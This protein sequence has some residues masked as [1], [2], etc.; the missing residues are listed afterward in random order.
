M[1]AST[2]L[3]TLSSLALLA[4]CGGTPSSSGTTSEKPS[5]SS[6]ISAE[7]AQ[8]SEIRP[9]SEATPDISLT[10]EKSAEEGVSSAEAPASEA[11][12]SDSSS[13]ETPVESSKTSEE[14]SMEGSAEEYSSE[15]PASSES[16]PE[17]ASVIPVYFNDEG[18]IAVRVLKKGANDK[19]FVD[20]T[21]ER[22]TDSGVDYFEIEL[23]AIVRVE[24]SDN[25]KFSLL[26]AYVNGEIATVKEGVLEFELKATVQGF[27]NITIESLPVTPEGFDLPLVAEN[28]DHI[29]LTFL[30]EDK[31]T[32]ILGGNFDQKIYILAT[33]ESDRYSVRSLTYTYYIGTA[34]S[35]VSDTLKAGEDGLFPFT[36][37][38]ESKG[39]TDSG[40]TFT[41]AELDS[42]A[43]SEAD[44]VGTYIG[45][46]F[47]TYT[48]SNHQFNELSKE[49]TITNSGEILFAGTT[50]YVD[51][52]TENGEI[53]TNTYDTIPFGNDILFG[54][55]NFSRLYSPYSN[56]SDILFVKK[57]N[58]ADSI[59]E[60]DVQGE[61]IISNGKRY[62]VI[63]FLHNG[64]IF[65][66]VFIEWSD[67]VI[68]S[69]V[70][71][72]FS[73]GSSILDDQTFYT[74]KENGE[75][76][77]S[78]SFAN[79]GGI[80][81]R[82]LAEPWFGAYSNTDHQLVILN[83]SFALFDGELYSATIQDRQI[84]L[85]NGVMKYVL[86][87]DF[88][89]RGFTIVSS[90]ADTVSNVN[91]ANLTFTGN[92]EYDDDY[93]TLKVIF[94]SGCS[95]ETVTGKVVSIWGSIAYA[96]EFEGTYS[97]ETQKLALSFVGKAEYYYYT[98]NPSN[99]YKTNYN[100]SSCE[101]YVEN[102]K[103]T[104]L[105]NF[106]NVGFLN[107]RNVSVTCADFILG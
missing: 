65:K 27:A 94:D 28:S 104:F 67:R 37:P 31:Q 36:M 48:S 42:E 105:S 95:G 82:V 91:F 93:Y 77:Q 47:A 62:Y 22:K 73:Y 90:E 97:S 61:H 24:L 56:S 78:I 10:S 12:P 29:T 87:I 60:Y 52:I 107:L 57:Q 96:F 68:H 17:E 58:P 39:V 3:L 98:S 41:V 35:R 20:I 49:L 1:K 63:S 81:N 4:S 51:R 86:D 53:Y 19:V 69:N 8:K 84:V 26:G 13:K 50:T 2:L 66:N 46:D 6:E 100:P 43:Y 54:S 11:T 18:G 30:A 76:L 25:D 32:E 89:E 92:Y 72:E 33:P 80:D 101:L 21:A 5:V 7:S 83:E 40:I 64:D 16:S 74:I 23:G 79:L 9:S 102:G 14:G 38:Y 70:E 88:N 99:Q 55:N 103:L 75:A 106:T 59:E 34:G 85:R 45:V 15:S 44:F 71:I